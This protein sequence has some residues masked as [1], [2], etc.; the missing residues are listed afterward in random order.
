MTKAET[1]KSTVNKYLA[2][3][4]ELNEFKDLIPEDYLIRLTAAVNDFKRNSEAAIDENRL[5][6]I[7][8][9]GQIKRGKSSFLN[10]FLFNGDAVLPEAAT[11]MTAALTKIRYSK[12]PEATIE[13]F[14]K[15]EWEKIEIFAKEKIEREEN[16]QR[17]REKKRSLKEKFLEQDSEQPLEPNDEQKSAFE[18]VEMAKKN[19]IDLHFL[20]GAKQNI[21]AE[22]RKDLSEK[23]KEY[24]GSRG[25]FTPIV[26]SSELALDVPALENVEI[27]DTPGIN[28][29]I[30]SR[31]KR[32]EDFM[33]Q[34]DVIFFLSNS[35]QFLDITDMQLLAQNIPSKGIKDIILIGSLFD[36]VLLDEGDKYKG[37]LKYALKDLTERKTLE[38]ERNFKNIAA[39]NGESIIIKVLE[40]S[41]PPVLIS[42]RCLDIA[43][44]YD[45][46]SE[47]QALTL[48]NLKQMFKGFNF[49]AEVMKTI[50]NMEEVEKRYKKVKENK[51]TILKKRFENIQSAF[52]SKFSDEL[53]KIEDDMANREKN[54]EEC[55]IEQIQEKLKTTLH[56]IDAGKKKISAIFSSN[57]I[58]AE[59]NFSDLIYEI[60]KNAQ[61]AKR[62]NEQ[63]G[64]EQISYS[65][66]TSTWWK[67]WTWGSSE[68]RYS[69]IT[70]RYANVHEAIDKIEDYIIGA[71]D[72]LRNAVKEIINLKQF[73]IDITESIQSLF[74]FSDDNF[75]PDDIL[76][77]VKNAV[78]RITIPS[79]DLDLDRHIDTIRKNFNSSQVRED[80]IQTLRNEQAKVVGMILKDVK[81][82]VKN[83]FNDIISRLNKIEEDFIPELTNDFK[84]TAAD[85]TEQMKNKQDYLK[86]YRLCI[87]KISEI[88]K[89]V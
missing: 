21:N 55:D 59:K 84:K 40:K 45:H 35:G 61:S 33:G 38:A 30:T 65:V 75:D 25:K 18:L 85:L 52:S 16:K 51:D 46:L 60:E 72:Q 1:I 36:G 77:P 19:E 15:E 4:S 17:I 68:T 87:K 83:V 67:P 48:N 63:Q 64:S 14:S 31:A 8:I 70:Y 7:G 39:D 32:T 81:S 37:D 12:T 79:V 44:N 50:S 23:L 10:S 69:T 9:I 24:V 41:F 13:F 27:I 29:P 66:S 88:S 28:D 20:L 82:E 53:K 11:P 6:R 74:D 73:K 89:E 57:A 78:E 22:N 5:M 26:K 80:E 76:I 47:T 54:L 71:K 3:C 56:K 62:V 86:K 49:S 42:S 2:N 34:C 58:H 43:R